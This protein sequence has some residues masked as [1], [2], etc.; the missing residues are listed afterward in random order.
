MLLTLVTNEENNFPGF[1]ASYFQIPVTKLSKCR[2]IVNSYHFFM[3]FKEKKKQ[4]FSL[5]LKEFHENN[6]ALIYID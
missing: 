2:H 4:L 6:I 3:F 5:G 1:K